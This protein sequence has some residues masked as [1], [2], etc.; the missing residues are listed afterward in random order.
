MI[1]EIEKQTNQPNIIYELS[2]KDPQ[3]VCEHALCTYH[4]ENKCYILP[5]WGKD[6][7]IYPHENKM[8]CLDN[9]K[10]QRFAQLQDLS[11]RSLR[12]PTDQWTLN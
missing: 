3:K 11:Y 2:N 1:D 8:I 9:E 5:V 10:L 12:A 6:F 4:T 7:G